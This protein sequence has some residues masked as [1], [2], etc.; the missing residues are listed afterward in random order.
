MESPLENNLSPKVP[1]LEPDR[2]PGIIESSK[3]ISD[4]K[5]S[6]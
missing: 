2:T 1:I 6:E 4:A 3:D 5:I